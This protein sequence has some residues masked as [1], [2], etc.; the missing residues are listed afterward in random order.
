MWVWE[1]LLRTECG[2]GVWWARRG[3]QSRA[4]GSTTMEVLGDSVLGNE[5][6]L[7]CLGIARDFCEGG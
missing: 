3:C 4:L 7:E 5:T 1:H 6:N 2:E